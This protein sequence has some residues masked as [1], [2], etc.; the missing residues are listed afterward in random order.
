MMRTFTFSTL[1]LACVLTLAGCSKSNEAQS[2]AAAPEPVVRT[3]APTGGMAQG[4]S[5]SATVRARH[6]TPMA[7]QVG[8]RILKRH[9]DASQN[10]SAGQLLFEIDPRDLEQGVQAS[11]ADLAAA[12]TAV[13]TAQADLMR[14]Q[15]L[16]SQGFLSSQAKDRAVLTLQEATSRRD[17]VSARLKQASNAS[18]YAQLRAPAA[19]VLLDVTAEA[20]QVVAAGQAVASLARDGARELEL[21]LPQ[22]VQAP[23]TGVARLGEQT[24]NL[25]LRETAGAV[26]PLSRTLR[27]R[28]SV[29][30]S[31]PVP[32][33]GTVL[34]ADF[35]SGQ[36][37]GAK[38]TPANVWT[39]PLASIDERGQGANVWLVRDGALVTV[40]VQV[41]Q[42]NL[43]QAQV[44]GDL[45]AT[46]RVVALGTHL[47]QAGMKVREQAQ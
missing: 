22:G 25:R 34:R 23:A 12:Q 8:G 33:P 28:Y 15:Q 38:P 26:D 46:D 19:G 20:G 40:P 35:A 44:Q 14:V 24:W 41:L 27:A 30:G 11:Q 5:V 43:E 31:A 21:N 6:E 36:A 16:V 4:L 3:V 7:F 9:V 32:L 42:V 47:L 2:P 1:T 39:L 29:S 10:V 17:A 37:E 45:Q 18:S 13:N